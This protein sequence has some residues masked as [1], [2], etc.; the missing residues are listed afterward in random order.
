MKGG[1]ACYDEKSCTA[2]SKTHLGTSTVLSPQH[3]GKD[4]Q[5]FDCTQ[6]PL[7]CNAAFA[8]IP[9][10]SGDTH[11]GNR[12]TADVG[13]W[14]LCFQGHSSFVNIVVQLKSQHGL[15]SVVK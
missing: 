8:F 12:S 7:F 2:R 4:L 14:N 15:S 3:P 5:S 6:N 1:G 10:L 9:Y 13:S 11:R